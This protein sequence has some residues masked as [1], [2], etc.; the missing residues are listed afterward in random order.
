MTNAGHNLER[1]RSHP[2]QKRGDPD[3]Q[4]AGLL[5]YRPS[6]KLERYFKIF[7]SKDSR[8]KRVSQANDAY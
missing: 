6:S 2:G 4:A 3:E 7:R 5:E 1:I 8:H